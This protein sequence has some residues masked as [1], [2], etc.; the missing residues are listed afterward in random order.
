[1]FE[2]YVYEKI[3]HRQ[4]PSMPQQAYQH[5]RHIEK[6]SFLVWGE[7]CV[8]CAAP[9]CYQTCELYQGRPDRRCRR[10]AFGVF[11]NKSFPSL[12]GHGAEVVFKKWAQLSARGNTSMES[13]H[14]IKWRERL[15]E[16][17]APILNTLGSLAYRLT[18]DIRWNYTSFVLLERLARRLHRRVS[19]SSATQ[20]PNAFLLEVYNPTHEPIRMQL[21][22][23]L[24]KSKQSKLLQITP[25]FVTTVTF[26]PGYTRYEFERRLFQAVTECGL[27]FDIGLTPEADGSASL[28]FLTADFVRYKKEAVAQ[29]KTLKCVVFDLDNTIWDGVLVENDNVRLKANIIDVLKE[30][31]ER[32]ILLSIAS[33]N[34]PELA[35]RQLEEFGIAEYFLYPQISWTPKS[36]GVK[37]IAERL[38]LGL[39]TFC[40]IDDN[41]FELEEISHA[42]P[43]VTCID[44]TAIARLLE[45]PRFKGSQSNEAKQRRRFYQEAITREEKQATFGSDYL[46]FLADCQ[47]QLDLST[48]TDSDRER[49][50]ELVQR[51]NQLNFS[52]RKYTT[53]EL[54]TILEDRTAEKFVL[55]CS[56]RYGGYGTVGFGI[57]RR[58]ADEIRIEDFMLS[59]RI[60]GKLIEQAFFQHLQEHHNQNR[61]SRLWINFCETARNKPAQQVLETLH[62]Q[63]E[64]GAPG[65][66]LNISSPISDR[67]LIEVK[68][69]SEFCAGCVQAR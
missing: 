37:A 3:F 19:S 23:R 69:S 54:V 9:F 14:S 16:F 22:M 68:C 36:Q 4:P 21:A 17:G 25:S 5:V 61:A 32:G 45:D 31:D 39:D 12:R 53:P 18:S 11:K 52:G 1:M 38:N 60:Q 28:V 66:L 67:R 29:Q 2:F 65:L 43:M 15:T 20:W 51:T 49:I 55:K 59:C 47:I 26:L 8:E 62:F 35:W 6:M 30:L 34:T 27:P 50:S 10:F 33:K 63:K 13:V 48:Y 41:P 64:E 46:D 57:V 44:A 56:D 42:L 40:F 7:H 58:G 24:A